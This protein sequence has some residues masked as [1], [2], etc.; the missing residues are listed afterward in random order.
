[1]VFCSCGEVDVYMCEIYT[2]VSVSKRACTAE[3]NLILMTTRCGYD[4]SCMKSLCAVKVNY[5]RFFF[6][7]GNLE[8]G[9][10]VT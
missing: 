2:Y 9:S 6:P 7:E 5:V 3:C 4:S 1:M 10:G 8:G